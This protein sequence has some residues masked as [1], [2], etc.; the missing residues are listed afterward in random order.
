MEIVLVVACFALCIHFRI[1]RFDSTGCLRAAPTMCRY[2]FI[3]L[4]YTHAQRQ[5]RATQHGR[6]QKRREKKM[7][8]DRGSFACNAFYYVR[9]EH[10]RHTFNG[11]WTFHVD[12]FDRSAQPRRTTDADVMMPHSNTPPSTRVVSFGIRPFPIR[13]CVDDGSAARTFEPNVH[14]VVP[15]LSMCSPQ[16]NARLGHRRHINGC[17]CGCVDVPGVCVPPRS[18]CNK[19]Q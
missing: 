18:V 12:C 6:R 5:H 11:G 2:T 4:T 17:L 1:S 3:P 13:V 8:F 10:T 15:R 19:R 7:P 16:H 9:H 14:T